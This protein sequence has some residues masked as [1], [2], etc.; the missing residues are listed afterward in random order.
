[1]AIVLSQ[2]LSLILDG[3]SEL[4]EAEGHVMTWWEQSHVEAEMEPAATHRWNSQLL[5]RRVSTL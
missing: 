3:I 5:S 2:F 1:M 4:C